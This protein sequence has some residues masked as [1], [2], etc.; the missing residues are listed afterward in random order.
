MQR[1]QRQVA[2]LRSK[3][4]WICDDVTHA[5]AGIQLAVRYVPVFTLV[6]VWDP[7]E[8]QALEMANEVRRHHGDKTAL[9]HDARLDV[10]EL[11]PCVGTSHLACK[12]E[13]TESLT[14]LEHITLTTFSLKE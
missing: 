4:H 1:S 5:E 14:H 3:R 2:A 12:Q 7:I 10:V 11:E 9:G 13:K 6:Q 8:G